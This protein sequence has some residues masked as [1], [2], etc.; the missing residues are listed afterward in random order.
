ME[1]GARCIYNYANGGL[2][3]KNDILRSKKGCKT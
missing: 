1:N 3:P 2:R